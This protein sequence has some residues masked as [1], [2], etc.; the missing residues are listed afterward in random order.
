MSE[1][2]PVSP[3]NKV[4]YA[5]SGFFA[6]RTA[7][8][9][10]AEFLRW[11]EGVGSD[12]GKLRERLRAI[13]ARPEI[14]E[15]I[16]IASPSLDQAVER[17]LANPDSKEGK[18]AEDSLV[19]YFAR[20][21]GRSTPFG[22]FSGCSV[23][24]IG[25]KTRLALKGWESYRRHTRLD[26]DYLYSLAELLGRDAN[27]RQT[28]LY[29]PNSS[30]YRTAGRYRYAEAR[31]QN[32]SRSYHLVGVE[33]TDY[34]EAT[35]ARAQRGA[36][37]E[38]LA[39]DL[40][41]EDI[42]IEEAREYVNELVD[43]QILVPELAAATTGPE[44][45]HDLIRQLGENPATQTVGS[46]LEGARKE[47]A[48]ID[49]SELG[50]AH[51]RYRTIA[52][53]LSKLPAKVELSRL[54]QIDMVK[55]ADAASIDAKVVEEI[56]NGV[57]VLQMCAVGS[58]EDVI[59]RFAKE[60][61]ERYENREIPLVEVL[62]EEVGIGFQRSNAPGAE[63]S[64]LLEGLVFPRFYEGS[65]TNWGPRELHLYKRLQE[66]DRAGATSIEIGENDFKYLFPMH[67]KPLPDAFS[68]MCCLGVRSQEELEKGEFTLHVKGC[69]GPSGANL[70]GRF[71]HGDAELTNFVKEHIAQEQAL[72]PDA[73]FAEVVHL[74][75]G[76]IG[77]ILLRPLLRDYEIPFLGRSPLPLE[78]QIPITDLMVSVSGGRVILRSKRLNKRVLPRLTSAHGYFNEGNLGMYRFLC[79]LQWQGA[80][81]GMSWDWGAFDRI[82]FLPRVTSGKLVLSRARWNVGREEWEPISKAKGEEQLRLVQEWR[83]KRKLPRLAVLADADNELPVDFDNVL[84]VESF[85]EAVKKRGEFTLKE[86]YPGPEEMAAHG[87]E[88]TFTCELVVPFVR[89]REPSPAKSEPLSSGP[90]AKSNS[91]AAPMPRGQ[92]S[93]IPGSEWLYA[94]LYTGTA[95]SDQILRE[96]IHPLAQRAMQ[97]GATDRWFFIRYGDPEWHLRVRF[98][99]TPSRLQSEILPELQRTMAPMLEDGRMW[100]MQLDTYEREV[101]RYGGENGIELAERLFHADSEAVL[102]VLAAITGDELADARWK[103]A[104]RGIDAFLN[105]LGMDLKAK[106]ELLQKMAESHKNE[107]RVGK[108]YF[109]LQLGDKYRKERKGIEG[110]VD[111]A[112]EKESPLAPAFEIF[113]KR[114][115]ALAPV[116]AELKAAEAASKLTSKIE[117][118]A[119]SYIHM[120]VNR[121]LRSAQR[122]Q[123]LVLY[124]FLERLYE[125]QIAR[126]RGKGS[127]T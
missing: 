7:L 37:L 75:E 92:R 46:I 52:E 33:V 64:P 3:E 5:A 18:D 25:G 69:S 113:R 110:M 12:R 117:D 127:S 1:T 73:V 87:P 47:L 77:N 123:E 85:L 80:S 30:L 61:S 44:P 95:S 9:P 29:R 39:K 8:L 21:S 49:D 34:L 67:P 83:S 96:V 54:F 124:D 2:K 57:R 126:A 40:A 120:N 58:A 74:P 91:L 43:S 16:F 81:G 82:A 89:K 22:L 31:L 32:K 102:E 93:F 104:L 94:K 35:L 65:Q 105:D 41:V 26:M 90:T 17:W 20:M 63:A 107:F 112:K 48:S 97:S 108:S 79:A 78:Q 19:R 103:L 15:G 4:E 11:G 36:R 68:V 118:L 38:D 60:F 122:A 114:S 42:T 99:G 125:S 111:A 115:V 50:V 86:I 51:E 28:L 76:R 109:K 101:E 23:G 70:L 24:K 45:I 71:C 55:P 106:Y 59:T 72:E 27:L 56:L 100:K 6:F 116:I 98:H 88:G 53:N 66:A 14:R 119:F 62:D 121:I 84:S 13:V 10:F